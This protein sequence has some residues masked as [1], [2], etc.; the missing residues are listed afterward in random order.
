VR[1]FVSSVFK[2]PQRLRHGRD[3]RQGKSIE[4][5]ATG[6]D[7]DS[8][9]KKYSELEVQ[10]ERLLDL[11]LEG[12][13]ESDRYELRV[14]Q[15]KRSPKTIQEEL[16][17]I[18]NRTTHIERLERDRNALLSHYSQMAVEHLDNL[19]L[20]ERN[21]VYKMLDLKVL[22]QEDGNLEVK[23]ALGG[24]P[25]RDNEPLPPGSYHTRGR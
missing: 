4:F 12:K 18:R 1:N 14:S 13:L 15:L 21:R 16:E 25:C 6:E 11:Y 3:A 19:E 22:A 20:E 9:L 17:H 5:I 2:G 24:N 7:E 8:W 10:E 23:W